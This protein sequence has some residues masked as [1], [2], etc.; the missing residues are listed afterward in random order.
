[1][2]GPMKSSPGSYNITHH[3]AISMDSEDTRSWNVS[4]GGGVNA[5]PE[6]AADFHLWLD[7]KARL[8]IVRK[9]LQ[10]SKN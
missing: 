3:Y 5:Y 10:F 2:I 7:P 8:V 6:I 4:K 9:R 1:M